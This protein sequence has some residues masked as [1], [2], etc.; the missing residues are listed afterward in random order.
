MK[1]LKVTFKSNGLCKLIDLNIF[2]IEDQ[3]KIINFY[4]YDDRYYTTIV[5]KE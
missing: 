4:T 3:E 2:S 5:E 1:V